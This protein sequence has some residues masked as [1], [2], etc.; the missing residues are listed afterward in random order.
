MEDVV[1]QCTCHIYVGRRIVKCILS[2]D[3]LERNELKREVLR[4]SLYFFFS[5]RRRHTRYWRDWSSDVCS[6]DLSVQALERGDSLVATAP[7]AQRWLLV[8]QPGPWGQEALTQ[9]RF[10]G[11][12]APRLTHREIGRASCRESE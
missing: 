3:C 6:S 5:S 4:A 8:E 1:S 11:D 10:D 12:V 9:S 2:I 7:P